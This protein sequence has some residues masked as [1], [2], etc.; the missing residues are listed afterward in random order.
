MKVEEGRVPMRKEKVRSGF[1]HG[2]ILFTLA[3]IVILALPGFFVSDFLF[4]VDEKICRS[5]F[6]NPVTDIK[7]YAM[8]PI[9]IAGVQIKGISSWY[10]DPASEGLNIDPDKLRSAICFCKDSS[11]VYRLGLA[12]SF[13]EPARV[14]ETTKVP[15]C[16][17]T[18]GAFFG[19]S[20]IGRSGKLLMN[21]ASREPY[22]ASSY[23]S[24][25]SHFYLFD[26]FPIL[27][28]FMDLPCH[29]PMD[30]SIAYLSEIDPTW[31]ND[32][33]SHFFTPEA[34][35]FANP[36][37]QV[38]CAADSVSALAWYPLDALFWCVG[39]W[40]ISYPLAGSANH[41]DTVVASANIA[42]KTIYRMARDLQLLDPGIDVCYSIITPVWKKTNYKIHQM[43]PVRGPLV[44]LGRSPLLWEHLKNPPF[45]TRKN[46]PDN[47]SWMVFR[48]VKCCVGLIKTRNY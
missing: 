47:F 42:A 3:F 29:I 32:L 25:N 6:I 15:W 11:G 4:A 20:E 39:S 34:A 1:V 12:V 44:P 18:I 33:M 21:A 24:Y 38:A 40:G 16:F 46:A 8:F 23:A 26:V 28:L 48:R 27:D 30:L 22:S 14:V 35:L 7:W 36:A 43:K 19:N 13:W 45:G 2:L 17:P 37:A 5:S 31:N 10:D 9:E 41:E